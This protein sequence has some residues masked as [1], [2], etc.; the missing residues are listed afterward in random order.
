MTKVDR[1]CLG[2]VFTD[3]GEAITPYHCWMVICS[4]EGLVEDDYFE[5]FIFPL[6]PTRRERTQALAMSVDCEFDPEFLDRHN[7][8]FEVYDTT[9]KEFLAKMPEFNK[10]AKLEDILKDINMSVTGLTPNRDSVGEPFGRHLYLVTAPVSDGEKGILFLEF[11]DDTYRPETRVAPLR[12]DRTT[13]YRDFVQTSRSWRILPSDIVEKIFQKVSDQT[14]N[15]LNSGLNGLKSVHQ[16]TLG[17][18][19]AERYNLMDHLE[20][21]N[22]VPT[23]WCFEKTVEVYY[24]LWASWETDKT[25]DLCANLGEIQLQHKVNTLGAGLV[26]HRAV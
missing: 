4:T 5:Y 22:I 12:H 1:V 25:G 8:V 7:E 2:Q 24:D 18:E 10:E 21:L 14:I 13:E 9:L 16:E 26:G 17:I 6:M 15:I 3:N 20:E 11:D 19:D 23:I